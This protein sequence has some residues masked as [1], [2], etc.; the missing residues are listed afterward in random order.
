MGYSKAYRLGLVALSIS[1]TGF[2]SGCM[3]LTLRPG[4]AAISN[5]PSSSP[6]NGGDPAYDARRGVGASAHDLLSSDRFKS[7][8]VEI[9]YVQGY[10]PT[11][12]SLDSLKNFLE[13][14]L[15]K[16]NGIQI[17]VDAPI[18][19]NGQ[20]RFSIQD[21]R[22]IEDSHRLYYSSGEQLAVY[23]LFLDGSS[24]SDTSSFQILGQSHRSTSMVIYEK[25]IQSDS[26]G[27]GRPSTSVLEATILMHEFGHILG[28]VNTGTEPQTQ[29]QDT[30]NGAHCNNQNCLMYYAVDTTDFLAN[31][32]GGSIPQL[33]ANC[34]Q[35]L[36]ANGGK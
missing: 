15:N 36:Q 30:A 3:P 7:L 33:D 22:S 4:D 13:E 8:L 6:S 29:H 9:Q 26:G 31:L 20:G 34:I 18:A 10:A 25:P 35:D 28:L 2:A 5:S 14:R 32:L 19:S 12:A 17:V 23:F 24:T 21:V 11:Q 27:I 16:P 1:L